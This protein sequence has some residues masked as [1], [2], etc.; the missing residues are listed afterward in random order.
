MNAG[1]ILASN[2]LKLNDEVSDLGLMLNRLSLIDQQ[3]VSEDR[4]FYL[5]PT[6]YTDYFSSFAQ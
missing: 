6:F 3:A 2:H 5:C 4:F 1:E